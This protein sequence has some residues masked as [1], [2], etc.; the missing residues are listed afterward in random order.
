MQ[1]V[2][3]L[4][5]QY[6]PLVK[7]LVRLPLTFQSAETEISCVEQ[8]AERKKR[9]LAET[10]HFRF[11][12][13]AR[14]S[15]APGLALR[16]VDGELLDPAELPSAEALRQRLLRDRVAVQSIDGTELGLYPQLPSTAGLSLVFEESA[17]TA[18]FYEPSPPQ[19]VLREHSRKNKWDSTIPSP[20]IL[21]RA[22]E[23]SQTRHGDGR[24][25]G[26][27]NDISLGISSI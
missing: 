19:L 7:V 13:Q 6:A 27:P 22:I 9:R 15:L 20:P 5:N 4:A 2:A 3:V 16:S 8:D 23:R 11:D 1:A 18:V 10:D 21:E 14:R 17:Y 26:E 12:H 25:I 24:V